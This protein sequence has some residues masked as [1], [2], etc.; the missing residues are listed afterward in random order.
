MVETR[1][2]AGDAAGTPA[3]QPATVGQAPRRPGDGIAAALAQRAFRHL[4][5]AELLSQTALNAIWFA[6]LVATEQETRSTT[7][8]SLVAVSA[9]LPVAL[10]GVL[11]GILVDRWDKKRV[12]VVSNLLRIVLAAGYLAYGWSVAVIF[13]MN[14]LINIVAQFFSP[15]LLATIPRLLPQRQ[16]TAAVGLFN[17]TLNLAQLLGM[18]LLGPP[19]L[20]LFGPD[21]VFALAAAVYAVATL[22]VIDLPPDPPPAPVATAPATGQ[23]RLIGAVRRELAEGWAFVRRDRPSRLALVYLA[24]TWTLLL[25]LVTLAPR[26][27]AAD[28]GLRVAAADA[29]YLLAPAGLGMAL[30]A[31]LLDRLTRRVGRWRLVGLGLLGLA[32]T[33]LALSAVAPLAHQIVR[34]HVFGAP[35]RRAAHP[36]RYTIILGRA[37]VAMLLTLL[38]GWCVGL[39]TVSSEAVL[40]ERAPEALRG[41]IFAFQLTVTNLATVL[42]LLA[43]GGLADLVGI[44]QV[45]GLTGVIVLLAWLATASPFVRRPPDDAAAPPGRA[46]GSE[47][48]G[49]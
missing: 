40:L 16:L 10:C 15:A 3:V 14:F 1:N 45:I 28:D 46:P 18:V 26:Y 34:G 21:A 37:G 31:G 33:L 43:V 25:A 22:L 17:V 38:A 48:G 41:R 36:A 39:V 42:P 32:A 27:A 5:L 9:T 6:A 29:S 49:A 11:A 44:N 47:G 19:L 4:W 13:A 24:L 7:Q 20:K 35:A 30:A 12:L 2:H 8:T 23:P